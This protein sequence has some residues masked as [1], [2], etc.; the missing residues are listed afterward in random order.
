MAAS[1]LSLAGLRVLVTRP[2]AQAES[3]VAQ[4]QGAG[5]DVRRLPL[6]EI[7]PV[8]DPAEATLQLI[9]AA[10]AD[11]WIFTSANAV[12]G[13]HAL[14]DA[15]HWRPGTLLAIGSATARA[16]AALGHVATCP[17]P[18]SA[19]SEG[20]L[21]L[22]PLQRIADQRIAIITGVGG[23]DGLRATLQAR[24]AVVTAIEVYRRAALHYPP[25]TIAAQLDG[26]QALLLT[27]GEA[28][29]ALH[30]QVPPTAHG[31][32]HRLPVL[33]PSSRVAG[34]ARRLGFSRII[35]PAAVSD[36][37][38]LEALQPLVGISA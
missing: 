30:D 1:S 3:L 5:A 11:V 16:L 29:Q 21:H 20:L 33:L 34:F 17:A 18:Q 15:A 10:S 26:L 13:A 19:H 7:Q 14:L 9:A 35:V 12:H 6:L 37:A 4:L 22:P 25:E 36:A 2:A 31:L 8:V 32:L 28:L 38:Y 24:G 27:S 23:R